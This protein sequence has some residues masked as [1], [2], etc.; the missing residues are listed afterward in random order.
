MQDACETRSEDDQQIQAALEE[1]HIPSLMN[2]LVHMTGDLDLLRGEI[3]PNAAAFMADPQGGISPDQQARVR[4]LALEVLRDSHNGSRPLPPPPSRDQVQEMI[5]FMLGR[6]LPEGYVDFLM[7]ELSLQGEDPYGCPAIEEIP[8]PIKE[9]FRVLIIGAGMSGLLAAI[10]L[11]QAGVPYV[12]LEK[13]ADVGGTWYENTYPGC[14]VD[15]PN[16]TYSYSFRPQDW[17][18]HFSEQ[19]V[20]RRYFQDCA[21]EY[22]L[23]EHIRFGTEVKTARF[24]EATRRWQ[25][26]VEPPEGGRETLEGNALISAVGQLNRPKIPDL[27][28]RERFAGPAFHSAAWEHEHDLAGKRIGVIGTGASAF[29]LV[30]IVAR[31]A[32]DLTVFQRTPPW[33]V[34][35]P[36][37]F[38]DIPDGKHW[39][40]NHVPFYA[41]WYRF[42][43]FWRS[44]EG[45]LGAC[46][47]DPA[48]DKGEQSVSAENDMLR[49]LL[50]ANVREIIG[51]DE[52]LLSKTIP[53]Y[54][55]GAKRALID[56]GAWLRSLK[57]DNV[58][59]VTDPI[60]EVTARGIRTADGTEHELDVL[61]YATGFHASEFLY[62]MKVFGKGGM[63]LHDVWKGEPR[64]YL[65]IT[66]PG[67]PNLFCTY[68]PNTNIVV[69]G[70]IIFFSECEMRYIL[71]CLSLL[72]GRGQAALDCK[73]EVHDAYN[74]R[75]DAGNLEMAW[76]QSS[77]NTWYKNESGRITQNWPFSLLEFWEQTRAPD[78]DDYIFR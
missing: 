42:N 26:E 29:Q 37:Y 21:D 35:N 36:D 68:G 6:E 9:K 17:P 3:R 67:F 45:L 40:L 61:I 44:A 31:E 58:R 78:P 63:E 7:S 32:A 8:E 11:G 39:L 22:G 71:G 50:T 23:R 34:P 46:R 24:D 64:A 14:R 38:K 4:A 15:S 76:G 62:P 18:Q 27:P 10:R 1:A 70:S 25:V 54:P 47:S 33:V 16:H 20:L 48:W 2:A 59:L 60:R 69:N 51:D 74:R 65:G 28:G 19:A 55:P 13:N 5:A 52:E 57:R 56:D 41:Q 53:H 66:V 75:I 49:A 43:V 77:V 72:L 73:Q 12:V 30:P